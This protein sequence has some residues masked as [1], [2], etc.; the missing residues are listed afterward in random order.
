MT[1]SLFES[2]TTYWLCQGEKAWG[3]ARLEHG[4]G[5]TYRSDQATISARPRGGHFRGYTHGLFHAPRVGPVLAGDVE[6]GAVIHRGADDRNTER[7]VYRAFE[8]DQLHGNVALIVIHRDHQVIGA[9]HCLQEDGVGRMRPATGNS[10]GARGLD[11][12]QMKR[13]SSSPNSP[14]SPAC[15]FRPQTA[16]RGCVKPSSFIASLPSSMVRRM[17]SV[18]ASQAVRSGTCVV[19]WM[20][21]RRSLHS[22]MRDSVAPHNSAMYSVWPVN[23][24]PGKRDGFLVQ[25]RGHHGFGLA[26]ETHFGGDAHVLHGGHATAGVQPAEGKILD[27]RRERA[28]RE[29]P[30]A[31]GIPVTRLGHFQHGGVAH[32]DPARQGRELGSATACR[33]DFGADAG[34]IPHGQRDGGPVINVDWGMKEV[35]YIESGYRDRRSRRTW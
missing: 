18:P 26:A 34:G 12:G 2:K 9:A 10:L 14:C 32:Y 6:R 29:G 25:R 27:V 24:A 20:V 1:E 4:C 19:T 13:W 22:S 23:G 21:E 8:I 30:P 31:S 7:D 35:R 17:R 33:Y 3:Q 5:R 28:R 15:G 16:M 11:G